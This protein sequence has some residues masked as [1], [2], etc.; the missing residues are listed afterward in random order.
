MKA[1]DFR[2]SID[3]FD[4]DFEVGAVLDDGVREVGV[5]PAFGEGGY[6]VLAWS[7]SSIPTAFSDAGKDS[8]RSANIR[9]RLFIGL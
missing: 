5:D 8:V 4:I 6:I 3:D 7:R 2:V 9:V 1:A